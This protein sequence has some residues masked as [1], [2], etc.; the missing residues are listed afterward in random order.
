MYH[1]ET[2]S[3]RAFQKCM[4]CTVGLCYSSAS[5]NTQRAQAEQLPR[6]HHPEHMNNPNTLLPESSRAFLRHVYGC[7]YHDFSNVD[8]KGTQ[9]HRQITL[10]NAA[11]VQ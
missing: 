6:S 9:F 10:R 2:L 7:F 5:E 3:K 8:V 1:C 11:D 4:P